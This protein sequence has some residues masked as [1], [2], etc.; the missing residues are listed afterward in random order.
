[1]GLVVIYLIDR[2]LRRENPVG[3]RRILDVGQ[4][5]SDVDPAVQRERLRMALLTTGGLLGGIWVVGFQLTIPIYVDLYLWRIARVHFAYA[6]LS[7][8]VFVLLLYGFYD[9]LMVLPWPHP[10]LA[11]YIP[12]VLTGL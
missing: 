4:A 3:G 8:A 5:E 12:R 1:V 10:L 7:A 2:F 11:D 6:L 9:W